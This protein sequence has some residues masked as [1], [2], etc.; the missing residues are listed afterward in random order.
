[1][2]E[3]LRLTLGNGQSYENVSVLTVSDMQDYGVNQIFGANTCCFMHRDKLILAHAYSIMVLHLNRTLRP[4]LERSIPYEKLVLCNDAIYG[5]GQIYLPEH[6][7][8]FGLEPIASCECDFTPFL[9]SAGDGLLLVDEEAV[10][11]LECKAA[12]DSLPL[13]TM[14]PQRLR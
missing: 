14:K 3:A 2:I 11:T 5:P 4:V 13:R 1:M 10:A 9:F 7:G 12:C 8:D 6:H